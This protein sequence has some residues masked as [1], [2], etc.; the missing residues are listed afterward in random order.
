MVIA[1]F[2][3]DPDFIDVCYLVASVLFILGIRG[4]SHPRT[5]RQ[6]NVSRDRDG[7]R[8]RR[9]AARPEIE[10]Y[11]L[12]ISRDRDRHGDRGGL[13]TAR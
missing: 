1:T 10:N 4:L 5:A 13:G 6:G 7:D 12:I 3:Q 2:L 11:G 9:D 8:G